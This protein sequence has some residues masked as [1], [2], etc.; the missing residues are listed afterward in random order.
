LFIYFC[1]YIT[2]TSN[3]KICLISTSN[4]VST[5]SGTQDGTGTNALFKSP[6]GLDN[7]YIYIADTLNNRIRWINPS[8]STNTFVVHTLAGS[9]SAAGTDGSGRFTH[10]V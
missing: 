2:E 8:I 4:I 3:N 9:G 6:R 1:I 5:V 7:G 10:T